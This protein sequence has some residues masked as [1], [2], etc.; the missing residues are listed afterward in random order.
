MS[1]C[2]KKKTPARLALIARR[3]AKRAAG[4]TPSKLQ[5]KADQMQEAFKARQHES[6]HRAAELM[7]DK[8]TPYGY[9]QQP[10]ASHRP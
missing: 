8:S 10:K 7:V 4:L 3:N 6:A 2:P 5:A 1:H 9:P